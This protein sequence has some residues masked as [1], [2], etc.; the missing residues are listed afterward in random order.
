MALLIGSVV[1]P[2]I[3]SAQHVLPVPGCPARGLEPPGG[4]VHPYLERGYGC[5]P[6]GCDISPA[7]DEDG[8]D[9]NPL[10]LPDR[11]HQYEGITAEY[12]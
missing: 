4:E 5:S 12:I 9:S 1:F 2:P 8:E 10:L 3:L 6:A 11:A 7:E